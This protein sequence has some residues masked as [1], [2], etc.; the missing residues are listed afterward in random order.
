VEA[1]DADPTLGGDAARAAAVRE[2]FEECGVLLAVDAAGRATKNADPA[3][4]EARKEI[5][6]SAPRFAALLAARGLRVDTSRV[7]PWAHWITPSGEP[8]RFSARF[9]LAEVPPDQTASHAQGELVDDLWGAPAAILERER[10]GQ[11]KLPPPTYFTLHE[12]AHLPTLADVHAAAASRRIA[13]ILPKFLERDGVTM[14]L[15]PWDAEYADAPGDA[16]A[17]PQGWQP[18][19]WSRHVLEGGRWWRR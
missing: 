8:V 5:A 18:P 4:V 3:L 7:H 17:M 6:A 13:T 9:F 1:S 12:L 10:A 11:L 14:I 15:L 16:L 19:G 2:A